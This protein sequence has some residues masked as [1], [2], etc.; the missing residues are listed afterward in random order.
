MLERVLKLKR[1]LSLAQTL[2]PLR[3]GRLDP[4][5]NLT[6]TDCWRATRTPLGPASSLITNFGTEVKMRAWGEGAAYLI[7]YFDDLI[8]ESRERPEIDPIHGQVH[9]WHHA[10]PGLRFPRSRAV[11]EAMV[12]VIIEQR[13]TGLEAKASYRRLVRWLS[14]PAPGPEG[15]NLWLP[16]APKVLAET[17]AWAMHRFGIEAKRANALRTAASYARRLEEAVEMDADAAMKRLMA[18]PGLGIWTANEVAV[19][20]LGDHDAFS[21]GDYHLKNY[22]AWALAREARASDERMIELLEPFRPHRGWVA[23][24]VMSSGIAPPKFGPRYN[25]LPIASM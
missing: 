7:E 20:A 11:F 12:P 19:P 14:E 6:K 24:L 4:T 17:P 21:I 23:R 13:V 16:I 18:L 22:V 10:M 15:I 9:A 2:G 1:P 5:V 25:P 3:H 8:G